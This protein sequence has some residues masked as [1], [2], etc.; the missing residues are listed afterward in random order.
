MFKKFSKLMSMALATVMAV[1][2]L[3][4]AK[5]STSYALS[6]TPVPN[7]QMYTT[8]GTPVYATPDVFSNV[9]M[10]LDRFVPVCV[11]GITDNG[12]YQVDIGGTFYIPGPYMVLSKTADKTEKQKALEN[13]DK[14]SEAY[15]NQLKQMVN[16]ENTSFALI[17]LTG[18]GVPELVSGDYKEIYTYYNERAVMMYYSQD[19]I[20][21]YYS[22]KDNKLLGKYTWKGKTI[23]EVYNNDTSL[24]PWGQFKCVST[25]ASAYK[26]K[27]SIIEMEYTN[28]AETRELIYSIL[29]GILEL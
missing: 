6:I 13:L 24:M 10:Y 27:A 26:S 18:D 9:A 11:T 25:D 20:T 14:F 17:D 3:A 4:A 23:W 7:V 12:F 19:P 8:S 2:M 29:K 22:K 1:S 15:V 5:P 16:Y 28:D 21:L